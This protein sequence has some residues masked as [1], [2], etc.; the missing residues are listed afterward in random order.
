MPSGESMNSPILSPYFSGAV[1]VKF[2]DPKANQIGNDALE[3]LALA[4]E[5]FADHRSKLTTY[6]YKQRI[7]ESTVNMVPNVEFENFSICVVVDLLIETSFNQKVLEKIIGNV[8][9]TNKDGLYYFFSEKNH[10]FLPLADVDCTSLACITQ[11]NLNYCPDNKAR[12][13]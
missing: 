4:L 1:I 10:Q 12:H 7:F 5:K 8:Y 9:K 13:I 6:T 3:H 2:E 11:M